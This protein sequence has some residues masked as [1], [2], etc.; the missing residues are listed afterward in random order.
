M[1]SVLYQGGSVFLDTHFR[2]LLAISN[3]YPY[4]SGCSV[5]HV[6]HSTQICHVQ[7]RAIF[8]KDDVQCV[9]VL[10]RREASSTF[11]SINEHTYA[12]QT[13]LLSWSVLFFGHSLQN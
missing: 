13:K 11:S 4:L 1:D 8:P 10:L 3:Y 5:S 9:L 12:L 7:S 6:T 2:C